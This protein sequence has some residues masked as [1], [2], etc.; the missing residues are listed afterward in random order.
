MAEKSKEKTFWIKVDAHVSKFSGIAF[1]DEKLRRKEIFRGPAERWLKKEEFSE[2][3]RK[4]GIL[5]E[6]KI[7]IAED[8]D[9]FAVIEV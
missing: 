5:P 8:G 4:N 2:F 3:A 6:T 9:T 1:A 7:A